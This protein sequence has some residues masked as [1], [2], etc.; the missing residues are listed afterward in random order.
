MP[1]PVRWFRTPT[2]LF[3]IILLVIGTSGCKL[4]ETDSNQ[5]ESP[6]RVSAPANLFNVPGQMIHNP[7]IH[8]IQ[9]H[10]SGRAGS[11]AIIQLGS[12]DKLTLSFELLEF[13][14][15]QFTIHFT[16][17]NADWSRSS[18]PP[19]F[20]MDGFYSINLSPGSVSRTQRPR[21][22]Q[23]NFEF[24]NDQFSF[25]RSGNYMLRVEDKDTGFTVFSLPFFVYENEGS[26]ASRVEQVGVRRN[27]RR[28]HRPISL[29]DLPDFVDQPQFDLKFYYTQNQF[30]G[31]S[32]RANELDFSDPNEVQF[33]L[34]SANAFIGD[35]EF[36]TLRIRDLSQQ[37]PQIFGVDPDQIP[38]RITLSDDAQGF[39]STGPLSNSNRFGLPN[40][41]LNAEYA[42]VQFIFDP[43]IGVAA[44]SDI[45]LVGDFTN[46]A[47]QPDNKLEYRSDMDRWITSSVVKQGFYNYKYV[48]VSDDDI[49]DLAFDDL[50]ARG[51]QEYHAMVYMRD[52]Q[53]FYDRLLQVNQFFSQ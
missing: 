6:P 4:F 32:R 40:L 29:F 25:T 45:Y 9:L 18:L 52:N 46:W 26:V 47:I 42:N 30:W 23:Y 37:N 34:S 7:D 49:N 36:L 8:S 22:R 10:R 38:P 21:Y 17:H 33:E 24:P 16:H 20:F 31:R 2:L 50:F 48:L 44:G 43:D 13:E 3:I 41:S 53:Q 5:S 51:R 15:R 27:L 39:S 28:T 35:Y 19:E 11:P 14:S 12:R 1:S